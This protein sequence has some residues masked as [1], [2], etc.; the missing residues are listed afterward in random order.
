MRN[1]RVLLSCVTSLS[2]LMISGLAF[3]HH[4]WPPPPPSGT[5]SGPVQ[6]LDYDVTTDVLLGMPNGSPPLSSFLRDPFTVDLPADIASIPPDPC[7]G[8]A[9]VWNA[10]LADPGLGYWQRREFEGIVLQ[11]MAANQCAAQIVRD[12]AVSPTSPA[13]IVSIQPI[14]AL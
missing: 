12:T 4:P 2:I 1:R 14:G 13:S 10:V 3:S 8:A 9:E 6:Q 7:K 5:V 11:V